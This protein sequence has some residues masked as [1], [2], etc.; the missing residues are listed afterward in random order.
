MR[1]R[2]GRSGPSAVEELGVLISGMGWDKV[3][4]V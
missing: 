3:F 2:A 4:G 1:S